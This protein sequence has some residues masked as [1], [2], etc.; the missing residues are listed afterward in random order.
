MHVSYVAIKMVGRSRQINKETM[1]SPDNKQGSKT[2]RNGN[3]NLSMKWQRQIATDSR[4][5]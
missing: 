1:Y 2:N 3:L 5:H 4:E